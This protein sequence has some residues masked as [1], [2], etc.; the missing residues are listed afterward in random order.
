[1]ATHDGINTFDATGHFQVDIHAVVTDEDDDLDT[2]ATGLVRHLLH[3]FVLN[4]K[5]PVG[6]HV[7][8]VGNRRV[9]ERLAND[10]AGHAVDLADPVGFA[11]GNFD[12]TCMGLAKIELANPD[13][14]R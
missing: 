8:R 10:G 9:G 3:V 13:K 1:V 14:F 7:A 4:A 5:G 6:H 11:R 2:F 12:A